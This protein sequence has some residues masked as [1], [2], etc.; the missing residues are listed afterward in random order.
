MEFFNRHQNRIKAA[1]GGILLFVLT[2]ALLI[3]TACAGPA[4]TQGPQ[5]PAGAAGPPGPAGPAGPPGP[6]GPAGAAGAAGAAGPAGPAGPAGTPGATGPAGPAG[7]GGAAS[8]GGVN[9]TVSFGRPGNGSFLAGNESPVVNIALRDRNGN[10]LTM[11]DFDVLAVYMYGPQDPAKVASANRLLGAS[12]NRSASTHHYISLIGVNTSAMRVSGG[13]ISYTLNPVSNEPPGTYTV[14]V[15]AV[16]KG[17]T[18]NRDNRVFVTANTQLGTNTTE[19]TTVSL[20]KCGAC[21]LG[22][23]NGQIYMHHIDPYRDPFGSPEIDSGAIATCKACHNNNGYASYVTSNG[24]RVVDNIIIRVHG[25]HMGEDLKNPINT[26]N[27]TGAFR[28]YTGVKFPADVKNCPTCHVDNNWMTKPSIFACGTCHDNTWFGDQSRIPAGW[29]AHGGG[30]QADDSKCN[31]CHTTDTVRTSQLLAP[32]PVVHN[33]TWNF[34]NIVG[35]NMTTPA[36]GQFYVAG[37][38]P[39]VTITVMTINGTVIDPN[40]MLEAANASAPGAGQWT[41]GNLF[42]SGPRK[43][44]QPVLTTTAARNTSTDFY[45]GNNVLKRTNPANE[46]ARV[47]RTGSSIVYQLDDV[48][49]LPA[50]TYTVFAEFTPQSPLGGWAVMNFQVGTATPERQI[51]TNCIDCHGNNRQHPEFFA[52]TYNPDICKSCHDYKRQTP[53]VTTFTFPGGWNGYGAAPLVNKA[54]GVHFGAYLNHPEDVVFP[55]LRSTFNFS[56][57]IFPQDVRNC[58]KCHSAQTTGSWTTP[59]RL[60]CLACHDNDAAK[61]HANLNSIDPTPNDPYSGDEQ[62]ACGTCHG[63]RRQFSPEVVHNIANPY[64][65]PYPREGQPGS[66]S[67]QPSWKIGQ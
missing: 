57:T 6:P 31:V 14:A 27:G 43:N 26:T 29:K 36:N 47:T 30:A 59:S 40:T 54:H 2:T 5:G 42:V 61:A 49:G 13:N 17:A 45:A 19:N 22:P 46:D 4:G 11:A 12:E 3:S 24:T 60:A 51:A 63:P 33:V 35:L 20:T 58:V 39:Q 28:F 44:A 64:Q 66:A 18:F 38:R 50:G 32:V 55:G 25:V 65:T 53:G 9:L 21:H 1:S 67:A 15:R 52:V 16:R 7:T 62:E 10:P 8:T 56:E 34:K 41:R 37:E 48:R 23:A